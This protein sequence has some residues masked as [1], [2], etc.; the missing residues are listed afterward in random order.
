MPRQGKKRPA[1]KGCVV[2]GL[3]ALPA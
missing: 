2:I 1:G 3:A